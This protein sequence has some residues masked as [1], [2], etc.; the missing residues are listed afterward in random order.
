MKKFK[1]REGRKSSDNDGIIE[2]GK[3]RENKS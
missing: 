3:G 1:I 2:D